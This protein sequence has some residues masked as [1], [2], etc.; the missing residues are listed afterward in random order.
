MSLP[1]SAK[2]SQ[3]PPRACIWMQAGVVRRKFCRHDYQ[4]TVC[5]YDRALHRQSEQNRRLR[6][7]GIAGSG[8]RAGIV[9][10]KD[11]LKEQ[12]PAKRPCLHHMKAR[13]DFKVC[14]NAYRCTDCEFD[15]YFDEQFSVHATLKPIDLIDIDGFKFPHGIYLHPGHTWVKI[16]EENTVRVGLDDFILRALG[17][18]DRIL[19]PLLGKS[20]HQD[21]PDITL[22]RGAKVARVLSP[23][24]GVVTATNPKLLED[25]GLG[26]ADAYADGW[27]LRVHTGDL[28]QELKNLAMGAETT[29]FIA[30]EVERLYAAI[31]DA[32]GPLAAD[33]GRLGEDIYGNLP[34]LGWENLARLFLR[35]R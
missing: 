18:L 15:Q 10:W 9:S 1:H 14:T 5:R 17:P 2:R 35:T 11:K 32:A 21:R 26:Y 31:E 27:I 28:R 24:S 16:E 29:E 33:G 13:V 34:Q 22:A 7:R 20:V 12:P 3:D 25:G 4:C 8:K 6:A 19:P 30:D 23:I